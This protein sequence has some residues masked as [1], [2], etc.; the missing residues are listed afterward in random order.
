MAR[1]SRADEE[2]DKETTAMGMAVRRVA[3]SAAEGDDAGIV[4]T[5]IRFRLASDGGVTVLAILKG[6]GDE[7]PVVAFIG[8]F[9]FPR[10][11]MS[12]GKALE[13]GAVKWRE[14]RPWKP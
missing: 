3:K 1:Q 2:W 12:C 7:G 10:A 13:A 9:D 5:D 4:L 8:A 14:D 11:V 6:T